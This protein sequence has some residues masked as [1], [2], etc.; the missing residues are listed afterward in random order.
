MLVAS[1]G[2]GIMWGSNLT[3][4]PLVRAQWLVAHKV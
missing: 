3:R 1:L 4:V 2:N